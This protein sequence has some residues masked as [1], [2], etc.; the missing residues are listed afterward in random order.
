[1]KKKFKWPIIIALLG[2]AVFIVGL[3]LGN[4]A[5]EGE[6]GF[7][8]QEIAI[9]NLD[10]SIEYQGEVRNFGAE[11]MTGI[12]PLYQL[13][14]LS[15]ARN[16]IQ[17]GRFAAYIIVPA[18]FSIHVASI[19][20][21]TPLASTFNFEISSYLEE[22]TRLLAFHNVIEFQRSFQERLSA[23]FVASILGTFRDG[24]D[25][26]QFVLKN[27]KI[28]L[29][30]ILGFDPTDFIS[31]VEIE[32]FARLEHDLDIVDASSYYARNQE[33]MEGFIN[34]NQEFMMM[35]QA[36][37][38]LLLTE[39]GNA[40]ADFWEGTRVGDPI[41]QFDEIDRFG[42]SLAMMEYFDEIQELNAHI[43]GI[44]AQNLLDTLETLDDALNLIFEV[45]LETQTIVDGADNIT[46]ELQLL[47]EGLE[48]L[49][50]ELAALNEELGAFQVELETLQEELET[51][52]EELT[53][54]QVELGSLQEGMEG[55]QEALE[56]NFDQIYN[57][58]NA[59]SVIYSDIQLQ[60]G[61]IRNA[62]EVTNY[63]SMIQQYISRTVQSD[64]ST[65]FADLVPVLESSSTLNQYINQ[66]FILREIYFDNVTYTALGH[67]L[68]LDVDTILTTERGNKNAAF[69]A[70]ENMFYDLNQLNEQILEVE[71]DLR[72]LIDDQLLPEALAPMMATLDSISYAINPMIEMLGSI[73]SDVL[74]PMVEA[75]ESM[76]EMLLVMT[77]E[78]FVAMIEEALAG[79]LEEAQELAT[80][81]GLLGEQL[82]L[83]EGHIEAIDL[84]VA[85]IHVLS[86]ETLSQSVHSQVNEQVDNAMTNIEGDLT[87]LSIE[88]LDFINTVITNTE[89][90]R[91][92]LS[93]YVQAV[94][95][96]DPTSAID[97]Q[98]LAA[99]FNDLFS[100]IQE[101][102]DLIRD[103]NFDLLEFTMLVME[104]SDDVIAAIHEDVHDANDQT[105][106]LI[107]GEVDELAYDRGRR[108][109]ENQG[110]LH[111]LTNTLPHARIGSLVNHNLV[112]ALVSPVEII[113]SHDSRLIMV[114]GRETNWMV[115]VVIG[116][117]IAAVLVLVLDVMI[118]REKKD[119]AV[120]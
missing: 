2:V 91:E 55:F 34:T 94:L 62:Q 99:Y 113:G 23:M 101:V 104:H 63:I 9:V 10:E 39:F 21:A 18:N 6:T 29:E 15:D 78:T 51:L 25:N 84:G 87:A 72:E 76:T 93:S 45:V 53:V 22:D 90:G 95:N 86:E 27:D 40:D 80:T 70:I 100:N 92:L 68:S 58:I 115:P 107:A 57:I 37:L 89:N 3:Y 49:Q 28:D 75:L 106:T 32:D 33:I 50:E 48:E 97:Q 42:V 4:F 14:G 8:V 46:A 103:S 5:P 71:T 1:M 66:L 11:L 120:E 7:F 17:E 110:L 108:S 41:P 85:E 118:A 13:T 67:F 36:E 31:F 73:S 81:T 109:E 96:H 64:Q 65:P 30:A 83:L 35:S 119:K 59:Q 79:M 88:Q 102:E 112:N 52:Q 24:Q 61:I 16:G 82:G 26:A 69:V 38:E 47:Q 74:T 56:Y 12:N 116:I 98:I 105:S 54:F 60:L 44:N 117:V 20:T 111:N 43:V 19:N 114:A 77:E